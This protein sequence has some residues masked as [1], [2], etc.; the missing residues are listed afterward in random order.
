MNFENNKQYDF[1]CR[2]EMANNM[3]KELACSAF[4]YNDKIHILSFVD[5][6]K[7]TKHV[8]EKISLNLLEFE[9]Y[10]HDIITFGG[11]SINELT[12][13]YSKSLKNNYLKKEFNSSFIEHLGLNFNPYS[14][15]RAKIRYSFFEYN[16]KNKDNN[17]LYK[18]VEF[19]SLYAKDFSKY[20]EKQYLKLDLFKENNNYWYCI[21]NSSGTPLCKFVFKLFPEQSIFELIK[22][23]NYTEKV[24]LIEFDVLN[25]HFQNLTNTSEQMHFD[26]ADERIPFLTSCTFGFFPK[27]FS[28][29][30]NS[31]PLS[32]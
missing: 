19:F 13:I 29:E 24:N 23:E 1:T 27:V 18:H 17:H 14:T 11:D 20:E 5:N 22:R 6:K 8:Y 3:E 4:L 2:F 32:I 12:E 21:S 10:Q 7:F 28:T 31:L 9:N 25:E 15:I 16:T 26:I 30:I